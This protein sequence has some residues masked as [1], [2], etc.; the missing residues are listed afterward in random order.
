MVLYPALS[1]C[2]AGETRSPI[3]VPWLRKESSCAFE[4]HV[5]APVLSE[6]QSRC[7]GGSEYPVIE[8]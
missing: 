5:S 8:V 2:T 1:I 6:T 3:P 4:M 7:V